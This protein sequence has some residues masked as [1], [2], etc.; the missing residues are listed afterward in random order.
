MPNKCVV[1]GCK[2]NYLTSETSK[3]VFKFPDNIELRAKWT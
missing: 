3:Q 2:T 1:T